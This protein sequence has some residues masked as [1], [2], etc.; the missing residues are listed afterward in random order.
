MPPVITID[1]CNVQISAYLRDHFGKQISLAIA[2]AVV[3]QPLQAV[4]ALVME[5]LVSLGWPKHESV[6]DLRYT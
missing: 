6:I 3:G 5:H 2:N 1:D 4:D